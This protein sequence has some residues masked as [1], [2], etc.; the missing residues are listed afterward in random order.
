MTIDQRKAMLRPLLQERF[1]LKFRYDS[2]TLP[3]YVLV[4]GKS[5]SK[6]KG[7]RAAR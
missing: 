4:I 2:R 7:V 1:D 5:G 6:L 3:F